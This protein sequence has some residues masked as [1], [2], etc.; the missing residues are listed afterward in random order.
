MWP[1]SGRFTPVQR[2]LLEII[3]LY[4]D[5]LIERI[6][7]GVTTDHI[8]EEAE[9]AMASYFRKHRFSK[10]IYEAAARDMVEN[11]RGAFSHL[12][13]MAVHDVGQYRT[14]PLRHGL[15]FSVDPTLRVPQENLYLRYEDTVVVT[16]DGVENFT[17]FLPSRLDDIE[18]LMR[19][20]G[21]LQKVPVVGVEP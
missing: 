6:R 18:A 3:R 1:V 12:V 5:E 7:P 13:G 20:E 14:R 16:E 21:V 9:T 19:E 8:L 2:E 10:N 4:R 15:V 11:G 17:D